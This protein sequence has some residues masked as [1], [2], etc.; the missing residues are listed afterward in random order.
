MQYDPELAHTAARD[1]EALADRL[2]TALREDGPLL[3]TEP[4]GGDEVSTRAADT[5]R[6]VGDSYNEAS[7]LVVYELR[8]LA[9]VV[10]SQSAGILEMEHNNS[11]A[12]G[13]AREVAG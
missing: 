4:A 7:D 13:A 5:L 1:L 10:R 8:K 3:R 11:I 12:L 2:S 9:A 6:R